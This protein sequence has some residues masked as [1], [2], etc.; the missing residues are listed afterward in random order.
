MKSLS[1][2]G[3]LALWSIFHGGIFAAF[4]ISLAAIGKISFNTSLFEILPPSEEVKSVSKADSALAAKTSRT[5][6]ILARSDDFKKAKSAA[7]ALYEQC[8][9]ET[10]LFEELSLYSA[11]STA[12]ELSDF[13]HEYRFNLLSDKRIEELNSGDTD[14][15]TEEALAAIYGSVNSSGLENLETDPFMLAQSAMTELLSSTLLQ[16]SVSLSPKDGVLARQKD[17]NWYV[18]LRALVTPQGASLTNKKSAVKFLYNIFPKIEEETGA[19]FVYSGVPFHSYESSSSA[20]REISVISAVS[21]LVIIALFLWIFRSPAPAIISA[22]SVILSC[23]LALA[24]DL[25]FFR[26]I[27]VLTFVFGTTLIGT[28]V[29]YS[30]HFFIHSKSDS[31]KNGGF[32]V[33]SKIFR[34]ILLGFLSS[35]ISF[36]A[37]FLA[38]FPFLK[39]ISVFLFFG[40]ASSFL[41]VIC[42][43]PILSWA[44]PAAAF[45]KL[46]QH[47]GSG[48]SGLSL[49]AGATHALSRPLQ[50][51]TRLLPLGLSLVS[52][53]VILVLHGRLSVKNDIRALYSMSQN[54]LTNESESAGV[55]NSG[56]TGAYFLIKADSEEALLEKSAELDSKLSLLQSSGQVGSWL[57]LTNFIPT[58]KKQKKSYEAAAALLAASAP[59]YEILGF[60]PE[61]SDIFQK[62]YESAA[63]KVILPSSELP[64]LIG[65]A[66]SSIYLGKINGDYYSCTLPLKVSNPAGLK[67]LSSDLTGVYFVNKVSDIGSQL[68]SLTKNMLLLLCAAYLAIIILLCVAYGLKKAAKTAAVPISVMLV[69]L[70]TLGLFKIP[71]SFFPATGLVLVFGLGLDYIIYAVE[72]SNSSSQEEA[73]LTNTGILLSF[74]T[75]ALSFGALALAA[76]PPV[77]MLGVTVFAGL[78]TAVISSFCISSKKTTNPPIESPMHL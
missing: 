11:A 3:G 78:T 51:L 18:L 28:G 26:S 33:R 55:I 45:D 62:E 49:T 44:F 29:D 64:S 46:K 25:L 53:V 47:G 27:H 19:R 20:Q 6:T 31:G 59:L 74:A 34:G 56:S 2:K 57:S 60:P 16:N 68:D 10:E 17:G 52:L 65:S 61:S 54:M 77:H 71:L 38:P 41:T 58:V 4:L 15:S 14:S 50:S 32:S 35:E 9:S 21:L 13:L 39:Q 1:K 69:T 8:K 73:S 5:L 30:I 36:A 63:K 67:N 22:L 42:L 12:Q 43:Y 7:A 48:F 40:L 72:K 76:F 66:L 70:A 37:L 24:A 23:S 75:S